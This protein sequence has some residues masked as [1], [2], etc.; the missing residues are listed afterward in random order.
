MA[1]FALKSPSLLAFEKDVR[2]DEVVL[3]N[4]KRIFHIGEV[5]SDT[6]MREIIDEIPTEQLHKPF[7]RI[8][9]ALQRGKDLEPYLFMDGHYL[10]ALDGTGF[11][12]SPSVNCEACCVKN[13]RS[14]AKTY[15][16]Q[17]VS[18]V[19]IHPDIKVVI[20]FSPEPITKQDGN[21]KNDCERRATARFLK[22]FR[23]EHPHM[24]VIITEDGLSSNAPH[25]ELLIQLDFHYILGCKPG[26]HKHLF[27]FIEG[28]EK[29]GAVNRLS[30]SADGSV[31]AFRYMND[32]EL[33]DASKLR[34]NFFE[35]I[36]TRKDGSKVTFTW[37]TDIVI[38]DGNIFQ[39]M[40]AG[41]AR[42]KIE[43]ETFNTL[44]NQGYQ[45]EHNF[46]HG[47]R[48]LSNNMMTLMML[49]FLIDQ[50]QLLGCRV[51]QKAKE[52]VGRWS[53]M[54]ELLRGL[55]HNFE[56]DGWD[57]LIKAIAFGHDRTQKLNTS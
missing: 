19:L 3:G 4:V 57:T 33:N 18:G 47:K 42:W 54:W 44:K 31:F 51:Y 15:Y 13:H 45:F 10:V 25:I 6:T 53:K 56:V 22:R 14:G 7:T 38:T 32:V 30:L 8:F 17:A 41:R 35:C 26:D 46:G 12:S 9:A 36:E 21:S 28:S 16:H 5:P 49:T 37:V 34:T 43:N 11:F 23:R 48:S 39:L 55:V 52:R 50:S 27:E 40:K 2:R 29:L 1:L 20:P 24:K